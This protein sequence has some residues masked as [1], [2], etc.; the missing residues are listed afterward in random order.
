MYLISTLAY[1]SFFFF[2]QIAL[3]A[4]SERLS[5]VEQVPWPSAADDS[6]HSEK[7]KS[8]SIVMPQILAHHQSSTPNVSSV[9]LPSSAGTEAEKLTIGTGSSQSPPN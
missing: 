2:R 3:R 6:K 8:V 5:K 7:G 4:L 9:K 1:L